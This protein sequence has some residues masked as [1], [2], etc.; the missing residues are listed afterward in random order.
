MLFKCRSIIVRAFPAIR[1]P[2]AVGGTEYG[3][4][5]TTYYP[6]RNPSRQYNVPRP[7]LMKMSL[8]YSLIG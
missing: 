8:L 7:A 3:R 5:P 6:Y 4:P 1:T 2:Y